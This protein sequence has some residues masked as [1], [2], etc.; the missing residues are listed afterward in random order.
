M[1]RRRARG[2][3]S[4]EDAS[5]ARLKVHMVRINMALL[6]GVL[7]SL[8]V[9]LLLLLN[10]QNQRMANDTLDR[11]L[12][13]RM[14][15]GGPGER[16]LF[17]GIVIEYDDEEQIRHRSFPPELSEETVERM[18]KLAMDSGKERGEVSFDGYSFAFAKRDMP[19]MHKLVFLDQTNRHEMMRNAF[20]ICLAAG[21]LSLL[22]LWALSVY[23]AGRAVRPVQEAFERQKAFVADASHELKTPLAIMN[24]NLSLLKEA[25]EPADP[26]GRYIAAMEGQETRMAG[27]IADM[28]ELARL[29]DCKG[30]APFTQVD[31]SEMVSSELLSFE[32]LL[33]EEGL[34]LSQGIAPGALVHG[35]A[36]SLRQLV[37]IL[38]DNACRHTPRGGTVLV[39]LA[40]EHGRAVL[41]VENTGDGIPPEHLPHVFDRFYRA[42]SARAREN[43]GYGLGLAIARAIARAHRAEIGAESEPGRFTRFTVKIPVCGK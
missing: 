25:T 23:L 10:A 6:S 3:T 38:L 20:F 27:L 17:G 35:D 30:T 5:L 22:A 36:A 37:G 41:T 2:G 21:S 24:A 40:P 33:F 42:D 31:L 28:L 4:A 29:D 11:M 15:P 18:M 1:R 9:V 19:N 43:G 7:V 12:S 13:S 34:T 8:L 14:Q 26:R 39:T 32:A 16:P